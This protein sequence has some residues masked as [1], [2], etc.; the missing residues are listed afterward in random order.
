M[1]YKM[2]GRFIGQI[3]AIESLFM[4]PALGISLYCKEF[5]AVQGFGYTLAI[6]VLLGAVLLLACRH[7]G[8]IFGAREGMVCV[9]F[10]W[11]VLIMDML[12]DRLEIFPILALFS[13][14]TWT[15]R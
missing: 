4:L 5:A 1:N 8:L 9:G 13:R 14:G 7:A 3:I 10:G 15:R 2:I 11:M 6:M 12:A